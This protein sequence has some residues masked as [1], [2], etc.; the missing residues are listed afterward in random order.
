MSYPRDI[1]Y[2]TIETHSLSLVNKFNFSNG[3]PEKEQRKIAPLFSL[4]RYSYMLVTEHKIASLRNAEVRGYKVWIIHINIKDFKCCD[5]A[6]FVVPVF[7]RGR[8]N[9]VQG[10]EASLGCIRPC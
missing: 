3:F 10:F 2:G 5:G 6:F 1:R 4:V 8:R 7:R 9:R